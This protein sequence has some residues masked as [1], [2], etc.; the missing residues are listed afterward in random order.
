MTQFHPTGTFICLWIWPVLQYFNLYDLKDQHLFGFIYVIFIR[1]IQ[2]IRK[3]VECPANGPKMTRSEESVRDEYTP[4]DLKAFEF[5]AKTWKGMLRSADKVCVKNLILHIP[6][7]CRDV[8]V[9]GK[10]KTS[11]FGNAALCFILPMTKL[12]IAKHYWNEDTGCHKLQT[13]GVIN[14]NHPLK[15]HEKLSKISGG[16]WSMHS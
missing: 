7:R 9:T 1:V 13:S 15:L 5:V 2:D 10:F 16:R 14:Q 12:P 4:D 8:C 3:K 11:D 6:P